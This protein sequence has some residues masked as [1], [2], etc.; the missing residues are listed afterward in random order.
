[1]TA[2]M[3]SWLLLIV[4]LPS[5]A[6]TVRMRIWRA[7]RAA[8]CAALRDGSYLLP[9][10]GEHKYALQQLLAEAEREEG[11][12]WLLHVQAKS[13]AEE[14]QLQAQFDRAGDYQEFVAGLGAARAMLSTMPMPE[15]QRQ[16]RKLRKDFETLRRID[17]FPNEA[18]RQA[19][20][21]WLD[22]VHL[23]ETLMSSSEPGNT[24][25]A[26]ARL[27]RA[28]YRARTWATR[29]GLWVDRVAC[30][31]LIR[32][33]I[34]EEAR[35]LWLASPADCPDD[36]LGFDFDHASF[37]HVGERV[38]FEVLMANFGLDEDPGLRRLATMVH[39]LD[40]GGAVVAEAA[41]F[42]AMLSGARRR[43]RNDDQLLHEMS[44]VLDALHEHFT[45][46]SQAERT[47]Q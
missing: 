42:E 5:P 26:I 8:G 46:E 2:S 45:A 34:D 20:A 19:A 43:A 24:G 1:M 28:D 7:A 29:R 39:A 11:S 40:V 17:F 15:L 22:F 27:D 18:S 21:A 32:R 16:T 33:F 4:S 30:A 35:F 9:D 36:A 14:R 6:A 10:T 47:K 25:G 13:D 12:G 41:G 23:A 44:S 38:S 37:T 3:T 31:W